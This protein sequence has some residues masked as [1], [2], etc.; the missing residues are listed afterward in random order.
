MLRHRYRTGGT[1]RMN[2]T[3]MIDVTF[4]LLTFFMLASHFASE[5]MTDV[6]L[7]RPDENQ[8]VDQRFQEKIIISLRPVGSDG[9]MEIRLGPLTV[10]STDELSRRLGELAKANPRA[11]VI[12][13]ADR[14]LRYGA[15]REVMEE[16]A[17]HG[18]TRLQV[19]TELGPER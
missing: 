10:E 15:V 11:Q 14:H 9:Q 5:E 7:P 17:A 2:M 4:L 16:V 8:A 12:L 3:P 19:V 6:D 1:V 18:L 13:R